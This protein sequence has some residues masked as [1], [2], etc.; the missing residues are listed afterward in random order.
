MDYRDKQISQPINRHLIHKIVKGSD[1]KIRFKFLSPDGRGT[2]T[3]CERSIISCYVDGIT[4]LNKIEFEWYNCDYS[5][6]EIKEADRDNPLD[7]S[8]VV[9][10][11]PFDKLKEINDFFLTLTVGEDEFL[12]ASGEVLIDFI[13]F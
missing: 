11:V 7:N 5:Y 12:F 2:R 4:D 8:D 1:I 6:S 9:I 10:T 13:N 3:E